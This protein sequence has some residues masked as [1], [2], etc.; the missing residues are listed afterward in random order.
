M[1]YDELKEVMH[2][3]RTGQVDRLEM[4]AAI[5]LWQLGLTHLDQSGMKRYY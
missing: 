2:L 3:Y 1:K 5:Q 4:V